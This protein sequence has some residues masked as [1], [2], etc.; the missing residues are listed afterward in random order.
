[1]FLRQLRLLPV[2]PRIVEGPAISVVLLALILCGSLLV[3]CTTTPAQQS[4]QAT[5]VPPT[6]S[7]TVAT[8]TPTTIPATP[9][10]PTPQHYTEHVLLS[11]GN[12]PDDLAFDREG[13]LL[14][15]NPHNGTV[16]RLNADGSVTVLLS[17]INAPEGL[18]VLSDGTLVIAEQ[19]PNRILT[20]AA[21]AT[22]LRVLRQ[23]PGVPSTASCKDGVDGIAF[24]ATTNTLIIPDSPM[25][26]VYRLS[27]DGKT[28][29]P[30]ASGIVRPVGAA[31]D[32][33]GNVYVTDECGGTLWRITPNGQKTRF[34]NFGMLDDVSIDDNGN[35]L[36]TDLAL[37]IHALIR[38]NPATGVRKTLASQGYI[39]PQGLV[40]DQHGNIFVAD[41]FADVIIEYTPI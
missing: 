32:A 14:F 27:L 36:V 31:V 24:D 25:G 6:P 9:T 13:R 22:S 40:L 20:L 15:S 30:L 23:L 38:F 2:S 18:V 41:D 5:S 7:K 3:S 8:P 12:R 11:G 10:R 16:N 21:G 26:E 37:A 34:G 33:K 1:M 35:I 29:T 19:G 4:T 28:L 39:E 17:G